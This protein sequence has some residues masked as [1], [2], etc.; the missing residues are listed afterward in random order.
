M[1]N[2]YLGRSLQ[3]QAYILGFLWAD[4]S[5]WE[6]GPHHLAKLEIKEAD[7]VYLQ[8]LLE[9]WNCYLRPAKKETWSKTYLFQTSNLEF[10]R[11]LESFDY[12]FKKSESSILQSLPEDL[13]SYWWRG[14]S[15]GDGGF[16]TGGNSIRQW[17]ASGPYDT[18]WSLLRNTLEAC[19]V[20]NV[21]EIKHISKKGYRSSNIDIRGLESLKKWGEYLYGQQWDNLGLQRK[22]DKYQECC[23]SYKWGERNGRTCRT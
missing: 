13:K 8:P 17:T 14:Y 11:Y 22:Y 15:D 20:H 3:E 5:L 10:Y 2:S 7:G 16:Y 4:G 18:D 1:L 12:K 19:G 23:I 21:R 6:K 9:K